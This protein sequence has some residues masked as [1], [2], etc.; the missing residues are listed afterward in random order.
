MRQRPRA[1]VTELRQ[2]I[3][4]LPRD[5][6][7]AMLEGIASHEIVVGA[8]THGDGICPMLAAHRHGGRT[9]FVAFAHAW[10]RLAFRDARRRS[11]RARGATDRE[12]LILRT[13]LEASLLADDGPAPDLALA[14]REHAGVRHVAARDVPEPRDYERALARLE[15]LER[16]AAA[17]L[18]DCRTREPATV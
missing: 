5:T 16:V 10:D 1:T 8:Y 9:T 11:R 4:C 17:K 15:A 13:Q 18:T 3:D 14:I 2:A 7:R 12:L 6:R